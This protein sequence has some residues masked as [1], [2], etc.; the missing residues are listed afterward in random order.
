MAISTSFAVLY[1]A[2]SMQPSTQRT[3]SPPVGLFLTLAVV[4]VY[5]LL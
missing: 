2:F 1:G 4:S 3:N 5:L